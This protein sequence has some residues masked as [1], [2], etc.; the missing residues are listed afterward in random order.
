[1]ETIS[2]NDKR[3]SRPGFARFLALGAALIGTSRPAAA[4]NVRH[5]IVFHVDRNEPATMNLLLNNVAN[6]T[7]YYS[8]VGEPVDVEVVAYG[9]GLHM[10]RED[11]SP[12]KERLTS[13][14]ASIP[15]VTFSACGVTMKGME[16]AEGHP[17]AL[18]PQARIVPAGVVR[19]TQL[20][21]EG[22]TYIK[23]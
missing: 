9:P 8:G 23:P 2:M 14:K 13:I 4:A 15:E 5:R 19:L 11:T 12:V 17:I 20:H 10:L 6:V 3:I 7:T 16:K 21:E 18:V 1:M 22:W